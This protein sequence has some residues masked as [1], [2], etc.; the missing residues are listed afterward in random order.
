MPRL[1][2]CTIINNNIYLVY[3]NSGMDGLHAIQQQQQIQ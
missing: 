2:L 3:K 1:C